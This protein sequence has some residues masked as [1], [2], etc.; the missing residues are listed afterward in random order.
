M[1]LVPKAFPNVPCAD[2]ATCYFSSLSQNYGILLFPIISLL[3]YF[4]DEVQLQ[5]DYSHSFLS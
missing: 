3:R 2:D 5:V 1:S 4:S